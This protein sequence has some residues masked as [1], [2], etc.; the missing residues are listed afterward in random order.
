MTTAILTFGQTDYS[1]ANYGG[2]TLEIDLTDDAI[3]K[4]LQSTLDEGFNGKEFE[5][6]YLSFDF[7]KNNFDLEFVENLLSHNGEI[8]EEELTFCVTWTIY[9]N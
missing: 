3:Q 4:E 1:G 5:S 7:D 9:N 6:A 8:I 2:K